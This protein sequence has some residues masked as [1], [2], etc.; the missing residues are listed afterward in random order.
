MLGQGDL[1]EHGALGARD[2]ALVVGA[3]ALLQPLER[4]TVASGLAQRLAARADFGI[5]AVEVELA[6]FARLLHPLQVS[7][8]G[9]EV[10]GARRPGRGGR[11]LCGERAGDLIAHRAQPLGAARLA[12]QRS[13]KLLL[14]KI[15]AALAQRA[16]ALQGKAEGRHGPVV[17]RA[18]ANWRG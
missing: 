2:G 5:V 1:V 12:V 6:D 7:L 8:V 13:G 15:L 3:A 10:D 4:L 14:G 11:A 17:G 9:C 18:Q 16:Q